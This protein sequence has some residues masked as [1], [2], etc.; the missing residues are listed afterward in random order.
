MNLVERFRAEAAKLGRTIVLPEGTDPRTIKAAARLYDEG[1][2]RPL[3]LGDPQ[4]VRKI[5]LKSEVDTE[6]IDII[7][8][9][10]SPF[11]EDF[12][13]KY[14]ELRQH[15]GIT[16]EQ[17]LHDVTDP[18]RFGAHLVRAGEAHGMVAGAA[19]ATADLLRAAITIIGLAPGMQTVSSSFLMVLRE[20]AP[21]EQG[22]E[23]L[24]FSDC[25]VIPDPTPDQL[26]DIALASAETRRCLVGDTPWVALLSFSTY[27]SASHG[28]VDKV[29]EALAIIKDRAP[30]LEADGELQADAALVLAIGKKK[31]PESTVA[32][33]ANVL[34]FPDLNS[35]NIGY[36]L[37]QRLAGAQALGPILQGLA[38]PANDLSRGCSWEDIY[39]LCHITALQ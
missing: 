20:P 9:E 11:V 2:V 30:Q 13:E 32:G 25:A 29:R 36:K 7:E 35:G 8:P 4:I 14:F 3:L 18:M 37:V 19:H 6:R 24:V 17:A 5:G 23:V 16:R 38:K 31:A 39:N 34:V 15:K 26:A 22:D 1:S 27:A 10:T 12:A 21:N 33:R 28:S